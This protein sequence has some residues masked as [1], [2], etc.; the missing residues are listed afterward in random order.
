M[1]KKNVWHY[2]FMAKF[3]ILSKKKPSIKSRN[4]GLEEGLYILI[5]LVWRYL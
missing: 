1:S 5:S 3:E 4:I 2:I